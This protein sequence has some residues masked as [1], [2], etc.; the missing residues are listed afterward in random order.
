MLEFRLDRQAPYPMPGSGE[1]GV[2]HG[3]GDGGQRGLADAAHGLLVSQDM[4]LDFRR[5]ADA[6]FMIVIEIGRNGPAVFKLD[7]FT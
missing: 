4:D 7:P 1:H 6:K 3:G 5:M 2:C